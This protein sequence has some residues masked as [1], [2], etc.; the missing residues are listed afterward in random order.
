VSTSIF[1]KHFEFIRCAKK[2]K[3]QHIKYNQGWNIKRVKLYNQ[4]EK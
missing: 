2:R 1:I 4:N 3:T